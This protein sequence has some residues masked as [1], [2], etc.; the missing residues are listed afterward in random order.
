LEYRL[1][2][3]ALRRDA[4]SFKSAAA[5]RRARIIADHLER[6]AALADSAGVHFDDLD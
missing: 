1:K 5:R 4:P 2:A 3:I 6:L